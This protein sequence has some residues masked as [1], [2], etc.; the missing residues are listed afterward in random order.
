M[1]KSTKNNGLHN[2]TESFMLPYLESTANSQTQ[3]TEI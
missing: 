1:I 2:Q 3:K